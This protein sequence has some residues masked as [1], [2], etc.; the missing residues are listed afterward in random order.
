MKARNL[1]FIPA[2]CV[3][4]AASILSTHAQEPTTAA[5][6]P[7]KNATHEI[8]VQHKLLHFPVKKGAKKSVVTINVD[9][10]EIR[11]FDIELAEENPEWWAPMDVSSW[12][13]KTLSIVASGLPEGSKVLETLRQSDTLLDSENLYQ[14][15]LRPQLQFSSK[16]GWLN[17]P[18]GLVFYNNE[19]H[20][21]YQHNPYG[22]NWGNMHWGHATS[23]DLVRWTEHGDVLS[24]DSS[25]A[26]FSGSA[27]VDWDNTSG[28]GKDGKP[29]LVLIFTAQGNPINQCVAY[30]T[31]GRTFT[32]YEG[33][34]VIHSIGTGNRDPKTIWHAP[35][36]QWVTVLYVALPNPTPM[37][38]ANG[39]WCQKHSVHFFTS[40]NLRDWTLASVT[41]GGIDGDKF[42]YECPDFFELALDGDPTKK[43]WILM[44][45]TTEYALGSF[46]GK[47]FSME[48]PKIQ[49][50]CGRGF[51]A[52]QTFSDTADGRRIQI[53]WHQAPSPGMAFNQLQTF[54]SELKL[55]TTPEGP[56][57]AWSPVREIESL[58]T[59]TIEA[60]AM[61]LSE[62]DANPLPEV[63]GELL[64]VRANFT[65]QPD[66][67]TQFKVRGVD[68]QYDAAQQQ[69]SVAGVKTKAPLRNGRQ[70][71]IILM[72]RTNITVW[73]SDG[74][75][76]AP[77]PV[78]AKPEAIG[79][80][81][82]VK[83]GA[84][85]FEKLA[86]HE[87]KSIWNR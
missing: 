35:T 60:P 83:G 54:P 39:K 3:L 19:Y 46:D 65:P 86:V 18:N 11:R 25:G 6:S 38:D 2:F 15:T 42:L 27:V 16:R 4:S 23:P 79:V 21:F 84:V 78:I 20:L 24:P 29:P 82:S 85:H 8:L 40:P 1:H 34:P 50:H 14:E 32:K 5:N 30:S 77:V 80:E 22:W 47:A 69:L 33:N 75:A 66:S 7:K 76:Y 44:G 49:G 41:D 10:A 72:D 81:V 36:K 68:V 45:A 70:N 59:K 73:A 63:R 43:R 71:L 87:L 12:A 13:G 51:Y 17:D 53:G 56:R 55:V 61:D 9:G 28:F 37:K 62:G 64:E 74:L 31:D 48:T 67:I 58:R 26:M 57:L 52:P